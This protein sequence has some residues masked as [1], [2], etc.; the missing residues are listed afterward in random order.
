[1]IRTE[2]IKATHHKHSCL[3]GFRLTRQGPGAPGQGGQPLAKGRIEPLNES[4]VN[5]PLALRG[6]DEP[7]NHLTTAL[8]YAALNGQ[9][10]PGS[11]AFD[12]LN[13]SDLRPRPQVAAARLTP[14]GHFGPKSLLKGFDIA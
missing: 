2:V 10:A 7:R 6:F 3:Q 12:H 11:T 1:M 8:H 14:A 13:D 5:V 4:G 9:L